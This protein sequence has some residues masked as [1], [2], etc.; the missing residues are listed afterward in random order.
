M[1]SAARGAAA[2]PLRMPRATTS[3]PV[4][5]ITRINSTWARA[6]ERRGAGPVERNTADSTL[7]R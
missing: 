3:F 4:G 7:I 6:A 5:S 2:G 1:Q